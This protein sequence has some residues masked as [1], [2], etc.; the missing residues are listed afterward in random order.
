MEI[1]LGPQRTQTLALP[2][3]ASVTQKNLLHLW[4]T[5]GAVLLSADCLK[6]YPLHLSS[7]VD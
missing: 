5:C 7:N 2:A 1:A 3:R 4:Y 6:H